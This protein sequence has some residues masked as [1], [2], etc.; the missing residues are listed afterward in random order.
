FWLRGKRA[1]EAGR[2]E[3]PHAWVIPADQ[4]RPIAA[5]QLVNLLQ[6]QGIEVHVA[7]EELAWGGDAAMADDTTGGGEAGAA[8]DT[9]GG[10]DAG[11]GGEESASGPPTSGGSAAPGAYVIRSDQPYRNLVQILLGEQKFPEDAAAPYDDTG[12]TLPYLH[13]VEAHAVDDPAILEAALRRLERPIVLAG[14]L[15]NPGS[16]IY[17]L[18]NSTD[19][20]VAVLRFRLADVQMEAAERAFEAGGHEYGAGSFL[21]PAQGNPPDLAARLD[22]AAT[23]LGLMVRGVATRPDVPTH[24]LEPP[25][26]ALVH[27]WVSTPQDAGWWTLVFDRIGIPYTY[28]SEQDLRTDDLSRFDVV[29]LPNHGASPQTLVQGT[30][31]AG[32][33]IPWQ[34]SEVTPSLG[35]IDETTDT[36]RGMGYEGLIH[37]RGFL[38]HGGVLITEGEAAAFP[39]EM[40]LT[41]RVEVEEADD[42]AA[43]GTVLRTVLADTASPIA[44]GYPDSFASYFDQEPVL[45]VDEDVGSSAVPDW[46]KDETWQK[47]V[48]RTVIE[49]A[50]TDVLMSGML[51]GEDAIAGTPAVV[52]VPVGEGHVVLFATHPF[53]RLET[54]GSHGLVF[55]TLL[56]WNDL[57][58]GWPERPEE[59]EEAVAQDSGA[60]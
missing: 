48:P 56:H 23:E 31:D 7:E 18:H 49:F 58:T 52:D 11:A 57:R 51:R 40:A 46:L 17:L 32:P 33:P 60:F 54:T 19:D 6:R 47:E 1:V 13:G 12:W 14:G 27:T 2:T 42:L 21:I 39:I 20:Q 4:R 3:A 55:N 10:G 43:R 15:E 45:D 5:A 9:T 16:P 25:R 28:L 36:R 22:A 37:L 41:R 44:Y 29:I 24:A 34:R 53:W 59:D 50:E 8:D 30:T 35:A 26:V 38:E